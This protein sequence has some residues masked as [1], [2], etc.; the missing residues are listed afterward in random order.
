MTLDVDTLQGPDETYPKI[1]P[2]ESGRLY[3]KKLD[4]DNL[5]KLKTRKRRFNEFENN[6]PQSKAKA[7]GSKRIDRIQVQVQNRQKCFGD[8]QIKGEVK[9]YLLDERVG[10]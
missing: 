1:R 3:N 8:S 9:E 5:D 6:S 10:P 2:Q 7:K 4:V